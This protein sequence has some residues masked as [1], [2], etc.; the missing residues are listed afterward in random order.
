M[1]FHSGQGLAEQ[2]LALPE[3]TGMAL[4]WGKACVLWSSSRS[5]WQGFDFFFFFL[6]FPG[7]KDL[8]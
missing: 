2:A 1:S 6:Y 3:V 5:S 7:P 8:L 4:L